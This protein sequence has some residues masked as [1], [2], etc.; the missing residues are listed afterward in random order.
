MNGHPI[1][2]CKRRYYIP[3]TLY[4]LFA[5]H[6]NFRMLKKNSAIWSICFIA[7]NRVSQILGQCSTEIR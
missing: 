4:F 7:D 5:D 1:G 3:Q 2:N 6:S